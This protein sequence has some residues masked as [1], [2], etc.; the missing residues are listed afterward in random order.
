NA[1]V[2]LEEFA[3][4]E[5]SRDQDG[6]WLFLLSARDNERLG[7]SAQQ[8]A[9]FVERRAAAAPALQDISYTLL[10]GREPMP[11]RLAVIASTRAQLVERLRRA[12][13]GGT[14]PFIFRADYDAPPA[15]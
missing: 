5:P 6:P 7:A 13:P 10:I 15:A 9:S 3:P 2:L 8:L 4:P 11:E 12:E 1:H 14:D